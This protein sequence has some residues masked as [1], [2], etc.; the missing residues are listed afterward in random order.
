MWTRA[1]H[2]MSDDF[3]RAGVDDGDSVARLIP[4]FIVHPQIFPVVLEGDP[5]GLYA[6]IDLSQH[7]PARR[8]NHRHLARVRHRDEEPL[9]VTA[10]YPVFTGTR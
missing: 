3:R 2:N 9:L 6:G 8:L 7:F 1:G 5:G 10:H 4:A